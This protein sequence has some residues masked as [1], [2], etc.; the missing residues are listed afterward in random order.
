MATTTFTQVQKYL[1]DIIAAWAA[2]NGREPDLPG[3]HTDPGFGWKT[4]EE[5]A[6]SAPF[7]FQLIAPGTTGV[8]SNLYVALVKGVTGFPR[9]PYQG[10]YMPADQTTY[11]AKWIDEGMPD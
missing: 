4:K 10:P 2:K 9:M 3:V 6:N 8:K 11:I 1:D 7:G 5:L